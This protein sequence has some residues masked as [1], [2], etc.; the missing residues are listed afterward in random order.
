M[1]NQGSQQCFGRRKQN[2]KQVTDLLGM[3]VNKDR[4]EGTQ[5]LCKV[6]M[7]TGYFGMI[8]LHIIGKSSMIY[9]R[10]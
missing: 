7:I 6:Y 2:V 9:I 8:I 1:A 10:A 3:I 5:Y 4:T